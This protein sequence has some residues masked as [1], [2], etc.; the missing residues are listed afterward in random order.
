MK[1]TLALMLAAIFIA[2]VLASCAASPNA[3]IS[4]NIRITSSDAADAAAW[5]TAR[6]GDK[7]T[8]RVVIGTDAVAY[9]VDVSTLEDDGY[10]I[11]SFG[12]EDV[13][14]AKTA[15]GLDRAV[16]KYAHAVESGTS[17][18]DVTYHEGYRVKSLTVA[19]N[20]VSE[21]AIVRA[22]ADDPCVTTAAET[23][24]EYIEKTCGAVL[25]VCTEA[26]FAK[27]GR[28]HMIAISSGDESLGDEGFTI[29]VT[30]DGT[31]TIMG[32]V[33]RGSLWGVYGLLEDI[34]WRFL[35]SG[36]YYREFLPS[37]RQ[38]YLYEA[39]SVDLTAAINRTEIP[40]VAIRGGVGGIKE[41]NSYAA[42]QRDDRGGWGFIVRASHGLQNNHHLVFSGDYEG[43]YYGLEES[44][45]QMCFS[46]EYILEAID[47]YAVNYV[48]TR[49]AAG[50]KIGRE[51]I[52]V[53]VAQWDGG[54]WTF[55]SCARCRSI[56]REEGDGVNSHTGPFLRMANR[57]AAL[58][59]ET[60]PDTGI[61][62]SILAYNGTDKL[63]AKTKP[64]HNLYI[65]YCFY[66][67][68]S[69]Y[70]TCS[71][72]C[73]SGEECDDGYISNRVAAKYFEDWLRVM[74]PK[75]MQVW[76]YP[77][78][79]D[80]V[81]YN[82]PIYRNLLKDMKYLASLGTGHVYL[83][84]DSST[85]NGTVNVTLA[86]YLCSKYLWD[87]TITE[88]ES[89]EIMREWFR[90]VYGEAGDIM[91]D[92]AMMEES[93]GDLAE[94]W[95]SF[96]SLFLDHVNYDY[97]SRHAE[98]IWNACDRAVPMAEDS[99]TE[100][101]IEKFC[102][103]FL[104][105]AVTSRYDEMYVNGTADEKAIITERYAE[106]WELYKKHNIDRFN[107]GGHHY[108]T[109]DFDPDV[110]PLLWSHAGGDFT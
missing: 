59:E 7:L 40:S 13:L 57:V 72:H 29:S 4:A 58:L 51:I 100:E 55:C 96:Y 26:Q 107:G 25:P 97:I 89:L 23:L 106:V 10:F 66:T 22:S 45:K 88:E 50:Q 63:P 84:V 110:D 33:W 73:I 74:D 30:E 61:C 87:A 8:D 54:P 39:E 49:L 69:T 104:Y 78:Q 28:A 76:Y 1:K 48:K 95:C 68:G 80:N 21:Y 91:F 2:S 6:L 90:L 86:Q 56:E 103:G 67:C 11:R 12:R 15:A 94:C 98:Y 35:A 47:A 70:L 93:A 83:C 52:S 34:G 31:L 109:K 102:A 53:D 37:D 62:A 24:A 92:L 9:G 105:I 65:S 20:D 64:A 46:D 38:E 19:G 18:G 32:G 71:N 85:N 77:F 16:R 42:Y 79:C 101:L 43:L 17:V 5:L 3:A 41:R 60:F 108:V 82:A 81:T 99:V 75:M 27:S 14:F 36:D 44:G